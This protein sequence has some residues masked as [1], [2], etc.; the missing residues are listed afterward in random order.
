MTSRER[1]PQHRRPSLLGGLF[2]AGS[3]LLAGCGSCREEAGPTETVGVLTGGGEAR[4]DLAPSPNWVPFIDPA[5]R[6]PLA[7]AK[8]AQTQRAPALLGLAESGR[9]EHTTA[10]LALAYSED[11]EV[12][13][14]GLS[15]LALDRQRTDRAAVLAVLRAVSNQRPSRGERLAAESLVVCLVNLRKLMSD[16]TE[17]PGIRT[18]AENALRGFERNGFA[19]RSTPGSDP[20][21]PTAPTASG[22]SQE[23]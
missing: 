5:V 21:A 23:P 19:N 18:E 8:I 3:A 16:P 20:T 11:V 7:L 22:P 10:L 6:E 12:V 17:D 1:Q 4:S 9:A 15:E 2:V 14:G 13:L